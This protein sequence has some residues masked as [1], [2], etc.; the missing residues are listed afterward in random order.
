MNNDHL[1]NQNTSPVPTPP[2]GPMPMNSLDGITPRPVAQAPQQ[3]VPQPTAA[4][5]PQT[6]AVNDF[7][8][9]PRPAVPRNPN[10]ENARQAAQD[11]GMP[12]GGV[13]PTVMVAKK[14]KTKL[15]LIIL[16]VLV[17]L[18]G[19]AAGYVLLTKK[20]TTTTSTSTTK[21]SS[22]TVTFNTWTGKGSSNNF[23]D[24]AN[25]SNG[26]PV[27]GQNIEINLSTI[28]TTT[29]TSANTASSAVVVS[30]TPQIK[31]DI[32]NLS[33]G[34][35]KIDG[36]SKLASFQLTG[37]ALTINSSLQVTATSSTPDM[38][39]NINVPINL[40]GNT[41]F[42][43]SG[44]SMVTFVGSA[45]NMIDLSSY[46]ISFNVSNTATVLENMTLSG[47]GNLSM[48]ASS[49]SPTASLK[50]MASSPNYSGK[51]EIGA[52]NLVA[53]GYSTPSNAFG[54]GAITVDNGGALELVLTSGNAFNLGNDLNLSGN[55]VK[56][57]SPNALGAYTGALTG[58]IVNAAGLC[59][60]GLN[61][62][63]SGM[64]MLNAN[65]QLGALYLPS[66]SAILKTASVTYHFTNLM[67]NNF[68][69]TPVA[70]SQAVIN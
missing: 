50:F 32:N 43:I 7:V 20:K 64:D 31:N 5:T 52:N 12:M 28:G 21:T 60:A 9:R 61:V 67:K 62:T 41:N 45:A 16:L 29:S 14:S 66:V 70:S 40:G 39:I 19:G 15:I 48:A 25:W 65:T 4:P 69:V 51:V 30:S 27:N 37:N 46:N 3:P 23:S 36:T 56:N 6:V 1:N 8:N 53:L 18:G 26:T 33:V 54:T 10:F 44:N 17:L 38:K 35:I 47:K 11:A 55:G 2:Q 63:L 68:T 59:A 57:G 13:Q 42:Q 49:V 34:Q 22:Q 24:A 58:C